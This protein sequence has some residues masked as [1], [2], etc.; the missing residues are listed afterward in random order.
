M[1]AALAAD[2]VTGAKARAVVK[3]KPSSAWNEI[4]KWPDFMGGVWGG[5]GAGGPEFSGIQSSPPPFKSGVIEMALAEQKAGP[6]TSGS[7]TC[8]PDGLPII[9]GGQFFFSKDIIF[10]M[11]DLD[12]FVTRQIHMDRKTHDDPD[13][14][15]FGDSIGHWDGDTLVVDTVGFLPEVKLTIL[16]FVPAVSGAGKTHIVERFRLTAPDTMEYIQ[17]IENDAVLTKPWVI[18][19]ILPRNKDWHVMETYCD[20]NNRNAPIDGKANTNMTP[21]KSN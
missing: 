2:A 7:R 19:R 10:L 12:F 8:S 4:A 16:N 9:V 14:T 1:H 13:P 3:A 21:P 17:T 5:R 11:S 15:F 20:Q 6:E 18:K